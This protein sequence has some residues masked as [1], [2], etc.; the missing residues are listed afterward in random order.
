MALATLYAYVGGVDY[1]TLNRFHECVST[2]YIS[3]KTESAA[4][5]IRN[6]ILIKKV[7]AGK[8]GIEE[9]VAGISTYERA[10][11]DFVNGKER[12]RYCTDC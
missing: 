4:I 1:S 5:A 6:A 2:G 11:Y 7:I 12:K 10:I 9:R 3:D 8:R